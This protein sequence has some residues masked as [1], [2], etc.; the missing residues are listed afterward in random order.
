M[1]YIMVYG[2]YLE[3]LVEHLGRNV[4]ARQPTSVARVAMVPT[5][6]I[7]QPPNLK[8]QPNMTAVDNVP[9]K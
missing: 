3:V 7:F 6:R 2:T 9:E 1:K 5:N 8:T 4:D